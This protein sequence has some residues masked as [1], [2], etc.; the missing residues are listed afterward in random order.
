[1][2][3]HD[4]TCAIHYS[5]ND[6]TR[7]TCGPLTVTD[8]LGPRQRKALHL[9]RRQAELVR[10]SERAEWVPTYHERYNGAGECVEAQYAGHKKVAA[11]GTAFPQMYSAQGRA[12]RMGPL[13]ANMSRPLDLTRAT[14][15]QLSA[16]RDAL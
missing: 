12:G 5:D 9:A 6:W 10:K 16:W 15:R 4:P 13:T 11:R 3:K 2:R 8:V 1:M 7:C 14:P